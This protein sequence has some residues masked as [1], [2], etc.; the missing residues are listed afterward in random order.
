MAH[1]LRALAILTENPQ[2]STQSSLTPIPGIKCPL[3]ASAGTG[4]A[5][6]EHNYMQANTYM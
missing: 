1:R 4:H 5:H 6:G 2:D 3:P